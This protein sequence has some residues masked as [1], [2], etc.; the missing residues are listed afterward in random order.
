M[1]NFT[2]ETCSADAG[3]SGIA[4]KSCQAARLDSLLSSRSWREVAAT[5]SGDRPGESL[6]ETIT[7]ER[8]II[9]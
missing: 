4:C 7:R 2:C 3:P 8:E 9:R 1:K 5:R 6:L